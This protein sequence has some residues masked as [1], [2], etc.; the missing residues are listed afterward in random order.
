MEEELELRNKE[1][2][3][4]SQGDGGINMRGL[5]EERSIGTREKRS[6]SSDKEEEE[7]EDDDLHLQGGGSKRKNQLLEK[8]QE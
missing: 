5:E 6:R 2:M 4:R 7:G 3:D 8:V 1:G